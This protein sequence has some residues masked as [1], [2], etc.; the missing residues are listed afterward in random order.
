[1]ADGGADWSTNVGATDSCGCSVGGGGGGATAA[2]SGATIDGRCAV[3]STGLVVVI[4]A[5]KVRT[6]GGGGGG[7]GSGRE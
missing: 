6:E 1:L 7:G 5:V 4:D 2:L 3:S